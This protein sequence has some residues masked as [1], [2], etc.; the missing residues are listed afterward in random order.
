M[1]LSLDTAIIPSK[2]LENLHVGDR[3]LKLRDWV[4]QHPDDWSI[5]LMDPLQQGVPD[6]IDYTYKESI[7]IRVNAY[8]GRI[9][10]IYCYG[11]FRGTFAGEY[12]IGTLVSELLDNE[13]L[14][15]AFDEHLISVYGK[16]LLLT[17]DNDQDIIDDWEEVEYNS[18][19]SILIEHDNYARISYDTQQLL[20][21]WSGS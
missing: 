8:L 17:V 9:A 3:S 15:L 12:G 10:S 19:E 13:E 16:A 14:L 6:F 21:L 18:I 2:G 4:V 1:L 5:T 20:H 7:R 11:N